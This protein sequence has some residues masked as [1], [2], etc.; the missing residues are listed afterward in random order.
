MFQENCY[1]V[2]DDTKECVIIDCG[3][4]YNEERCAI[5]DY[6]REN[7]LIPKHL[8]CTHAHIDHNFGNNFILSEYGLKPEVCI[9]D[10]K[11]I[12]SLRWQAKAF[13]G[14]NYEEEIPPVSHFFS[15]GD[16]V[17]FGCHTLN[18]IGTPGHS[19]GSVVIYCADE[20]VAFTGDTLFR[21]SI[22]RTDL[23]DG[24]FDDITNSLK[25]LAK[26]LPDDVVVM[27]GHGEQTTMADEKRFNPY[28]I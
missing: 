9:A 24:R 13:V 5:A 3:A 27:P 17:P 21:M 20:K 11:L 16:T 23:G 2:S 8:V 12:K 26:E 14:M 7:K 18:I 10:K 19:P 15:A 22:G 28:F 4:L 1:V 6:I 25:K